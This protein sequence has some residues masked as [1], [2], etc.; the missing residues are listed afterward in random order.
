MVTEFQNRFVVKS[1]EKWSK[2]QNRLMAHELQS[3][4]NSCTKCSLYS[5]EFCIQLNK[6]LTNVSC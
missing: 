1:I 3:K 2:K 6:T 5:F 4:L